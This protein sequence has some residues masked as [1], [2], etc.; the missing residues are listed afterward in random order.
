MDLGTLNPERVEAILARNGAV[1]ITLSEGGDDLVLEPMPG[2]TPLWADTRIS[3]LFPPDADLGDLSDDLKTTLGL[4]ALPTHHFE[5]L[6][7]RVWEREWLKYFR[8]LRFGRR[9][10]VCPAGMRAPV[11]DSVTIKLDPGLAFGTG[12]HATTALCL[13]W[14]DAQDLR[15]RTLLD[16]GCGSGVLAI[17]ALKLGA[18]HADAVDIDPQA[19]LAARRNAESNAVTARLVA[20]ER[21]PAADVRYDVVIANILAEPLLH[22]AERLAHHV[23][24]G[25]TLAM[26]GI[27]AG[28]VERV[29]H[30]YR[31][32][33]EFDR[34]AYRD[35]GS[36]TWALLSGRRQGS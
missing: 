5:S 10:W 26:S 35:D 11:A 21:V 24:A 20:S 33:I 28:E 2:E 36:Q 25:G 14:L 27:L 13:E 15:G 16:F 4:T 17:A 23:D 19:V 7:D 18:A 22:N 29:L 3:G 12:T 32:W 6:S 9:L 34:P 1:S 31:E 8:P 30:A